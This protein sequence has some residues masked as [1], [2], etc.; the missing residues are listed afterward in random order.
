MSLSHSANTHYLGPDYRAK[1]AKMKESSANLGRCRSRMAAG[2][3]PARF[4]ECMRMQDEVWFKFSGVHV[5]F[6]L[7]RKDSPITRF[8][9]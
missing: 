2:S 9:L 5:N 8:R 7:S 3:S 6:T 1:E 4:G